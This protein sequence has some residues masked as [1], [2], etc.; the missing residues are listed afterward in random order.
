MALIE[1]DLKAFDADVR[2]SPEER[3]LVDTTAT[4]GE[5]KVSNDYFQGKDINII[6]IFI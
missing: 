2:R 1:L 5:M 4:R 3:E 6:F